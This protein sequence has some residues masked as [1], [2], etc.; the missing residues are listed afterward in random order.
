MNWRKKTGLFLASQSL[1]VFGSTI[2]GFVIIWHTTLETS[3]G[4]WMAL[5]IVC[6]MLPQLFV[7]LWAGV[8]ADRY[9][10]RLIA[11]ASDAFIALVTLSLAVLFATGRGNLQILLAAS[12]LRSLGAG[13]QGPAMSAILPQIVPREHL[14]RVNGIYQTAN[15]LFVLLSPATAALALGYFGISWAFMI[16]VVTAAAAIGILSAIKIPRVNAEDDGDVKKTVAGDLLSGLAYTFGNPVLRRII[17]CYLVFFFLHTPVSFLTPVMIERSFGPEVWRLSANE[18]I[19]MVGSLVGGLYVSIKGEFRD[20]MRT[21]G[22][23]VAAFGILYGL[24]GMARSFALYL[25]IMGTAGFFLPVITTAQNVIVQESV[26]P[27]LM[28]RVFSILQIIPSAM[29]PLA[30]LFYGPLG[31]TV[32]IEKIIIAS[33]T[34]M[35][36]TGLA[37]NLT[38]KI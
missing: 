3:S 1:S 23:C 13:I 11:I 25:A 33:G 6:S 2:V 32:Q 4:T 20:K 9:D 16:D 35:V 14:T 36:L 19:W 18:I 37:F 21:I 22:Y 29:M 28:G 27:E 7:S 38:R 8:L 34:L 31:D 24:L 5:A 26:E 15:S 10:R 17:I 12:A 30:M